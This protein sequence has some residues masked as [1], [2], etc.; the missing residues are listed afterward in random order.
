MKSSES[1]PPSKPNN[2]PDAPTEMPVCMNNED[3]KLPP[4]PDIT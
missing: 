4:K 3:S 2:A 1:I